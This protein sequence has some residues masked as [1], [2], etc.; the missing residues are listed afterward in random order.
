MTF[1]LLHKC[2]NRSHQPF[3]GLKGEPHSLRVSPRG[4]CQQIKPEIVAHSVHLRRPEGP[5]LTYEGEAAPVVTPKVAGAAVEG[6]FYR[7][8][9]SGATVRG[10]LRTV[11]FSIAGLSSATSSIALP[12]A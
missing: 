4:R 2:A 6:A 11:A 8:L 5:R 12:H 10:S 9:P 1:L 7:V 3:G